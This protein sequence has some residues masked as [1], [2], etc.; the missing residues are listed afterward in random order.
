VRVALSRAHIAADSPPEVIE[1]AFLNILELDPH[2]DQ[3][4]RNLGVFYR[5]TGRWVEGEIDA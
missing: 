5:K 2:N 3:A 4:K 1:P